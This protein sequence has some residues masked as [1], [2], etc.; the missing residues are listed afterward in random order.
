MFVTKITRTV[1]IIMSLGLLLGLVACSSATPAAPPAEPTKAAEAAKPA[2]EAGQADGQELIKKME[3]AVK[4]LDKAHFTV[5]F[6][7][8]TKG[9]GIKGSVVVW[10]KKP[11]NL[12]VEF[13]SETEDLKG[14]IIGANEKQGWIYSTKNQALATSSHFMANAY[15]ATQPELRKVNKTLRE[16]WD[17]GTLGTVEATVTGSETVNGRDT[18]VVKTVSKETSADSLLTESSGTVW[19]DKE[20]FLPQ[21]AELEVKQQDVSGKGLAVLQGQIDQAEIEASMFTF[22]PPAG[23]N[24]VDVDAIPTPS[25]ENFTDSEGKPKQDKQGTIEEGK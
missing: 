2:A 6:Q 8:A 24:V 17:K 12:R 18:Y 19:I 16:I 1:Y 21:Q 10:G 9:G 4:A 20:T 7:M 22:T 25:T 11:N 5:A 14:M 13:T 3:A 15:L 23:T